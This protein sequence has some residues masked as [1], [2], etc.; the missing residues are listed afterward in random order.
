MGK[1]GFEKEIETDFGLHTRC[2]TS[3]TPKT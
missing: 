3:F 2:I 1:L